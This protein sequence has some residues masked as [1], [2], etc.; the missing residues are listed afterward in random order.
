MA[1]VRE[2]ALHDLDPAV[3]LW[4]YAALRQSVKDRVSVGHRFTPS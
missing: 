1:A 3:R 4:R 2:V